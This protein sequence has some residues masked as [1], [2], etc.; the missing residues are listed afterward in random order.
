MKGASFNVE[1][2]SRIGISM[3]PINVKAGSSGAPS[4]HRGD[5]YSRWRTLLQNIPQSSHSLCTSSAGVL[6]GG[7]L[8]FNIKR[9]IEAGGNKKGGMMAMVNSLEFLVI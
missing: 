1:L 2:S 5:R 7:F 6:P 9:Q 8:E 3:S 4:I